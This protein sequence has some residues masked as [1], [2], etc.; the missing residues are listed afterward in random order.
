MGEET[1]VIIDIYLVE[2]LVA[3]CVKT[4]AVATT[5]IALK[6]LHHKIP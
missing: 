1:L 6:S 5:F 3:M 2:Q 4:S